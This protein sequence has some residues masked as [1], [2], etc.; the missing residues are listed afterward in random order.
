ML[1]LSK[2]TDYA[3]VVM[4]VLAVE[5]LRA[6][7]QTHNAVELAARAQISA[8]T[9]SKLLKQLQRGGLVLSSRGAKGGYRLA[10]MPETITVADV[11]AALEGPIAVTDCSVH[12]GGCPIEVGCAARAPLRLINVAIRQALEAVTMA[13]MAASATAARTPRL[14]VQMLAEFPLRF[15]QSKSSSA[16]VRLP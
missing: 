14:S 9:V 10:R 7:T 15:V 8:T 3:T 1:R 5:H 13:D 6:A 12:L 2:L 11:I 4:A 16:K